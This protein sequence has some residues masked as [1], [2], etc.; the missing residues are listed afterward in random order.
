MSSRLEHILITLP[1]LT[2]AFF[3]GILIGWNSGFE[4][5]RALGKAEAL[6]EFKSITVKHNGVIDNE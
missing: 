2:G 5:G 3:I 6:F 1:I 4:T